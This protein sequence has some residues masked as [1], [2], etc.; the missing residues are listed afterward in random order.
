M[1]YHQLNAQDIA[2]L[3]SIVGAQHCLAGAEIPAD[4]AHDELGGVC[5]KPEALVRVQSTQEVADVMAWAN[6]NQVSV[7]VRGSGTGL[8]GPACPYRAALCWKPPP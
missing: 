8:V 2:A 3:R 7:T 6:R 4:Y 5:A 1:S